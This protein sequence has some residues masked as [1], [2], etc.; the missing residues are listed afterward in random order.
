MMGHYQQQKKFG[1]PSFT[2]NQAAKLLRSGSRTYLPTSAHCE[3]SGW[4]TTA[5]LLARASTGEPNRRYKWKPT[6]SSDLRFF[7]LLHLLSWFEPARLD[8]FYSTP[9]LSSVATHLPWVI[10]QPNPRGSASWCL[11]SHYP[12]AR[13]LALKWWFSIKKTRILIIMMAGTSCAIKWDNLPQICQNDEK[14]KP[15]TRIKKKLRFPPS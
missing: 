14:P 11:H 8:R 6:S 1:W 13:R 9:D 5:G 4:A 7:E 12:G 3:L 2:R 10:W 15:E